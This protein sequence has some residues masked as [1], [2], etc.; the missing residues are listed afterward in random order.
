LIGAEFARR[1]GVNP[2]IVNAIASH[3]HEVEQESLEAIIVEAADAISG[4]RPGARREDLE[5]YIK[6]LRALE[7]IANSFKGV[8]QSY[9]IQAGREVRIIVKPEDIDD[10]DSLRI[11]RDVAKKI[12]ENMQYPGQIRVTVI[13]ETRAIDYAK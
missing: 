13:R 10:L 4:A 11:A 6:R 12:E 7:D 1:Y 2:K 8:S 9:A 3:H 5:Q